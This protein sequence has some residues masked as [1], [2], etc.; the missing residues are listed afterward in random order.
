MEGPEPTLY[1]R[2]VLSPLLVHVIL[3]V[4]WT[5]LRVVHQCCDS[6]LDLINLKS[7][8]WLLLSSGALFWVVVRIVL[9]TLK[10]V[11]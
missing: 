2:F 4:E 8:S 11:R 7:C 1:M 10:S 3:P 6:F 5:A 9:A